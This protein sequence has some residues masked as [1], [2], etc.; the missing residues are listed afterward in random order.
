M[1]AS[2]SAQAASEKSKAA[3]QLEFGVRMALTGAWREAAFRFEKATRSNPDNAYAHNNLGV[4]L[5]SVGEFDRALTAYS[6]A[7]ELLPGNQKILEN[8]GRL[9]AYLASRT[10][11]ASRE[12][13]PAGSAEDGEEKSRSDDAGRKAQRAPDEDDDG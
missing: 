10:H 12:A 4:S 9:E 7:L 13:S 6:R 5:E 2:A 1:V 8:K 3:K 11:R